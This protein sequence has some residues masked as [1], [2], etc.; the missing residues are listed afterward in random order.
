M[1]E[2]RAQL[3][4]L[5]MA[6]RK[7]RLVA[8]TIR[9]L[10]VDDALVRLQFVRRA[11]APLIAKLVKSAVANAKHNKEIDSSKLMVKHVTVDEAVA[12]KRWRPAAFGAVHPIKKRGSHIQLVLGLKPGI[13]LM[14]QKDTKVTKAPSL[15]TATAQVGRKPA[16]HAPK[17]PEVKTI[18]K[19]A[20]RPQVKKDHMKRP[21]TRTT[22]K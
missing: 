4:Y 2:I 22:S 6:P 1:V 16:D 10:A 8:D 3:K 17:V 7:V 21:L 20:P 11:A 5:R 12:L 13:E 19:M 14:E 18:Q 9:G 15:V